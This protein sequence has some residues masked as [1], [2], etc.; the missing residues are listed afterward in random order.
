MVIKY[1]NG[2]IYKIIGNVPTDPCYVGST[3]KDYL[4]QRMAKHISSY[5][6]WKKGTVDKRV[7][8][9]ELFDK[10]G[11]ENC[12]II[13]LENVE[14]KSK[15]ELRQ[16]EQYYIDKLE[17]VNANKAYCTAD[18]IIL[19]HKQYRIDNIDK[20]KELDAK[21]YEANKDKINDQSKKNYIQNKDIICARVNEYRKANRDIINEKLR[22]YFKNHGKEVRKTYQEK[23]YHC[24]ECDY[25][26]K[27]CKKSR[28]SNC[29]LH[30]NNTIHYMKSFIDKY[31]EQTNM[32]S[33]IIQHFSLQ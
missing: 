4:S 15:D 24:V 33:N 1:E 29:K 28:H 13:L 32:E 26:V 31:T 19:Y 14:A 21:Y 18:E 9:F 6:C 5:R 25:E 8:S 22:I 20:I 30:I 23:T 16:R 17:C 3:T 7:M 10:Y 27:L 11:V 2:K 12:K